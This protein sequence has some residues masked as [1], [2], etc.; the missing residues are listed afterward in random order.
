MAHIPDD[1]I[2][3]AIARYQEERARALETLAQIDGGMTFHQASGTEPMRD[4][5]AE[6]RADKEAQVV[7]LAALIDAYEKLRAAYGDSDG[8]S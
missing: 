5:T 2:A 8:D 4:V 3:A 1:M 7:Q 6:R